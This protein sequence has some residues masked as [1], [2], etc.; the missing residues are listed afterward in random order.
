MRPNAQPTDPWGTAVTGIPPIFF[1]SYASTPRPADDHD[2]DPDKLVFEFHAELSRQVEHLAGAPPGAVVGY[3]ER[4]GDP[5][6]R[7]LDALARCRVFVPL[8]SP[9]YFSTPSCGQQWYAFTRRPRS[10]TAIVPALWA[11]VMLAQQPLV[12]RE[13]PGGLFLDPPGARKDRAPG[14]YAAEGLYSL[15]TL[16]EDDRVYRAAVRRLAEHIVRVARSAPATAVDG[17]ELGRLHT[18]PDA[19]AA[20]P[21]RPRLGIAVLAPSAD[22]LPPQRDPAPYGASPLDWQPYGEPHRAPL[23]ERMA[24]LARNLGFA[25][26]I[27]I[28]DRSL[29]ELFGSPPPGGPWVLLIDPW[30]LHD[31]DSAALIRRFDALDQ[32]WVAVLAALSDHD[33]QNLRFHDALRRLLRDALPRRLARSRMMHRSAITGIPSSEAFGRIFSELVESAGLHFLMGTQVTFGNRPRTSSGGRPRLGID[34][35]A[36]HDAEERSDDSGSEGTR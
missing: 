35:L 5:P 15:I 34:G 9:R 17:T 4:P 20:S 31:R 14:R 29:G 11:P 6:V 33:P 26:E 18:L 2:L 3:A 7:I 27:R 23:A 24:E 25:P 22:R 30:T 10:G 16:E 28:F 21:P 19:F 32:P 8:C 1:L 13:L 12:A 36:V